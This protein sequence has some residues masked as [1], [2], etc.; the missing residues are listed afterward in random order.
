MEPIR[1]NSRRAIGTQA[2]R[3]DFIASEICRAVRGIVEE[4]MN[5]NLKVDWPSIDLKIV[6]HREYGLLVEFNVQSEWQADGTQQT[7]H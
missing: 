1:I 6:K 5:H 3:E 7:E 4:A 2:A